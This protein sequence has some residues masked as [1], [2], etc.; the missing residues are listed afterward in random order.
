[1]D[2]SDSAAA[3][4]QAFNRNW[5]QLRPELTV[6]ILGKDIQFDQSHSLSAE[7]TALCSGMAASL[8]YFTEEVVI[9]CTIAP[10]AHDLR[11][12]V[13]NLRAWLLP[14]FGGESGGDGFISSLNAKGELSQRLLVIAPDGYFRWR[15]KQESFSAVIDKL[16]LSRALMMQ[17]P[18]RAHRRQPSLY[19]LRA[20]FSAQLLIGNRSGA[21]ETIALLDELQLDSAV[22]TEFM[23][24]RMW[25][26]FREF[27]R[28]RRYPQLERL[29]MQPLPLRVQ[30][31][32]AE[33]FEELPATP[34]AQVE[35]PPLEPA[36]G[37]GLAEEATWND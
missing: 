13:A 17:R 4:L 5:E 2:A 26:H 14:S 23:R 37:A 31:C 36:P 12:A 1:M 3:V 9:W 24:I 27:A 32:L 33:A 11:S 25:H 10:S 21:E 20:R 19:E 29:R 15:C 35:E 8:P 30:Q 6:Q 7:L 34:A 22:N 28:I 16:A 18:S